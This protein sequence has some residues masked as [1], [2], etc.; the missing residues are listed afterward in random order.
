MNEAN[1]PVVPNLNRLICFLQ[2]DHV[3]IIDQNEA[4]SVKLL[5]CIEGVHDIHLD[6]RPLRL[7]ETTGEP[8][9]SQRLVVWDVRNRQPDLF[10]SEGNLQCR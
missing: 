10:L 1:R 9:R 3:R 8:V 4:S 5:E 6:D 7:V 2:Q